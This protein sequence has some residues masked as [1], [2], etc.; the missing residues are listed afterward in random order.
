MATTYRYDLWVGSDLG[1]LKGKTYFRFFYSHVLISMLVC[2]IGHF[3]VGFKI[4]K[5]SF[6]FLVI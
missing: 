2:I 4:L 6:S 3:C 5:V 1:L